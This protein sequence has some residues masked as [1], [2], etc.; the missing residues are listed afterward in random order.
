MAKVNSRIDT[1]K[2]RYQKMKDN[3]LSVDVLK[4]RKRATGESEDE[5][6]MPGSSSKRARHDLTEG[7]T[8]HIDGLLQIPTPEETGHEYGGIAQLQAA[9]HAASPDHHERETRSQL[10]SQLRSPSPII[11]STV[12]P[13]TN[14]STP[15]E[16][17]YTS[18]SEV[19]PR[20]HASSVSMSISSGT[21]PSI[22]EA[23]TAP[24]VTNNTNTTARSS[25][26]NDH[27]GKQQPRT[28]PPELAQKNRGG[29]TLRWSIKSEDITKNPERAESL[30]HK[31]RMNGES[32]QAR[33]RRVARELAFLR[34][35]PTQEV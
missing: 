15:A 11:D 9:A 8:T 23:A 4:K 5:N 18:S 28:L 13:A 30:I 6:T 32:K 16:E 22:H 21:S 2:A 3:G 20:R 27:F 7:D 29:Q 14:R 25:R 17:G 19:P 31:G 33:R 26:P 35:M 12:R 24:A 10:D 34:N 1:V